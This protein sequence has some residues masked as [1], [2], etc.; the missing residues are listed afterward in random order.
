MGFRAQLA[1]DSFS[2]EPGVAASVA[3][4]LTNEGQSPIKLEI[5]VEGIDPEWLAI[6]V[7]VIELSGGE[8]VTERL[9][10]KPPREPESLSGTYPFV[11]RLRVEGGDE[12]VFP[13]SLEVKPY[14]NVSI[15]VQ[16][17]RAL[18]SP[19]SRTRDTTFQVTVMNLGNVEQTL[20]LFASDHDE[21]FAFEFDHEEMTVSPGAQK[22]VSVTATAVKSALIANARLQQLTIACRSSDDKT[23]ATAT[24]AQIEQRAWVT[25]GVM[26]LAALLVFILAAFIVLLPKGPVI[27]SFTVTPDRVEVGSQFIIEWSSTHARSVELN[28]DGQVFGDLS[29]SGSKTILTTELPEL[30]QFGKRIE[31]SIRAF[32]GRRESNV[33]TR[34]VTI[35][36][37]EVPPDPEILEFS[38]TPT[39]PKVGASYIVQ[40]KLSDSVTKA[41]LTP[42]GLNLDVDK[43]SET[44]TAVVEG[45]FDYILRVENSAGKQVERSIH[46]VVKKGSKASIIKFSADPA[47]VDPLDG[48]VTL[49]WQ[50]NNASRIELVENGRLSPPLIEAQGQVDRVINGDTTFKLIVYDDEGVTAEKEVTVKT[51]IIDNS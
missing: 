22:T 19:L 26:W 15:D 38:I 39:D 4:E 10:L 45:E 6:P 7:P 46:I 31:I 29:P 30:D 27:D 48:R 2:V 13:C 28:V 25:P 24:H 9:F 17:R 21:L 14:H 44:L 11:V 43:D 1:N 12:K 42:P 36:Q 18:V 47:F 16:P 49:T 33:K 37:K 41:L 40:Y 32:N 5:Q 50:V 23:V 20:K 51:K 3:I 8:N 35:Q 34:L